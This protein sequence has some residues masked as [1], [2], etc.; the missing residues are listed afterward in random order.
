MEVVCGEGSVLS[1]SGRPI[2]T[3]NILD[4]YRGRLAYA[5]HRDRVFLG[6]K[7]LVDSL[8]NTQ[9]L[10]VFIGTCTHGQVCANAFFDR[11][12]Q[13]IGVVVT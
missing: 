5:N 11:D 2:P 9:S 10:E 7:E 6:L 12:G 13:C 4:I 1:F 8:S 3:E